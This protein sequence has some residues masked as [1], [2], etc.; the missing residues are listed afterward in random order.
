MDL[1]DTGSA[2]VGLYR[3]FQTFFNSLGNPQDW[4]DLLG[5]GG[6]GGG[7]R[8]GRGTVLGI[9][10]LP[11]PILNFSHFIQLKLFE[12]IS[13]WGTIPETGEKNI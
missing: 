10:D 11:P 13:L 3:L 7:G 2:V 5:G 6:G 9:Q 4:V 12:I 8:K 1:Y